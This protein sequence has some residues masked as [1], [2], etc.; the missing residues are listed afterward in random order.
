M[1]TTVLRLDPELTIY[2][3]AA[4]REQLAATLGELAPGAALTLE[5][6]DVCEID[7][8]GMQLL[9]AAQRAAEA[10]GCSLHLRGH[11]PAVLDAFHLF[12]LPTGECHDA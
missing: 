8:A 10:R 9:I 5:L 6:A 2:G 4:L 7:S 11:S 3:A 12:G 1:D